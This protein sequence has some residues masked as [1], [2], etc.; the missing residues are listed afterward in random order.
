[1]KALIQ[2]VSSASV[3]V[4]DNLVSKINTGLLILLGIHKE[5]TL[6]ELTWLVHKIC[7]LRVFTDKKGS[8]NLSIQDVMGEVLVVSQFT[9][10]ANTKKGTRPSFIEAAE[11]S[12]AEKFYEIFCIELEKNLSRKVARGIFGAN[13]QV[14]LINNGPV[15]IAIDT[16][17]K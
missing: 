4:N 16:K 5:D 8:M 12:F 10:F 9:L 13:M 6:E 11:P 17:Q 1:M 2:R 14:S 7:N 15:T 3:T